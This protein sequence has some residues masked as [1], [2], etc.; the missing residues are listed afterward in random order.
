MRDH[1]S[2]RLAVPKLQ[3]TVGLGKVIF[4]LGDLLERHIRR[5]ERELFPLFEQHAAV[6]GADEIAEKLTNF[7]ELA[8]RRD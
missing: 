3:E 4:D 6:I 2:V 5:E 1:E 7:L 8:R